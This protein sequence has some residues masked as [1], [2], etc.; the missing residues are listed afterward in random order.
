MKDLLHFELPGRLQ[1]GAAAA[2]PRQNDTF[3]VREQA[4]RLCTAGVEAEDMDI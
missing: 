3:A 4:N 2:R 1:V